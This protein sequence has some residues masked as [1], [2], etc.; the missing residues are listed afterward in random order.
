MARISSSDSS[1]ASVTRLTPSCCASRT[2]SAL[3]ML[4]CVLAWISRSGAICWASRR[5]PT[6]CTM[7]ASAPASAIAA[8]A[9]GFFQ[10]VL[11]DQRVEGDEAFDA[12]GVSVR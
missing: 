9:C 7:S 4:I 3:V 2:P 1:R 8:I 6:S 10:L 5:T 11:E 12:A